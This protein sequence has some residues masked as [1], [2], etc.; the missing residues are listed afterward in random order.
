MRDLLIATLTI[1]LLIGGWL[2]FIHYAGSQSRDFQK[3][4]EDKILP[5]ITAENWGEVED[6]LDR[7]NRDWHKFRKSPSFSWT[8]TPSMRLISVWQNPSSTLMRRMYPI[9]Q[10]NWQ[11]WWNSFL[12]LRKMSRCLCKMCSEQNLF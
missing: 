6:R 8:P 5:G 4:I 11:P 3:E 1:L 7:L 10:A 9:P 2:T 12:S